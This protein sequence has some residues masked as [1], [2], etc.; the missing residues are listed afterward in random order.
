MVQ[1][2]VMP[3]PVGG[4]V[5]TFNFAID[6]NDRGVSTSIGIIDLDVIDPRSNEALA[7]AIRA[8]WTGS[9]RPF[10]GSNMPD[11]Y[12]LT[13]VTVTEMTADG[14]ISFAQGPTIAGT[15]GGAPVPINCALLVTKLTGVG[16]RRNKGRMYIP[17]FLPGESQ[18]DQNG[19][20]ASGVQA[21]IQGQIDAAVAANEADDIGY[22]LFHQTGSDT[23]TTVT[24]LRLENLIATQRRRMRN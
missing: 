14:P 4:K 10:S 6:G 12:N 5:A 20:L 23:P 2:R 9:G 22:V 3:I 17:P 13:N 7:S 18:V 24:E 19:V 16:G 15:G 21:T 1:L 11:V 8:G